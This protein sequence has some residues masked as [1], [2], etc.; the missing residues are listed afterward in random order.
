[1]WN[2]FHE[3]MKEVGAAASI[4]LRPLRVMERSSSGSGLS[5]FVL[6]DGRFRTKTFPQD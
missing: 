3:Q 2:R 1:M 4:T 6:W 5:G